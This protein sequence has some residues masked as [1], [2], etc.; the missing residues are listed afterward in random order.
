MKTNSQNKGFTLIE[1]VIVMV[2]GGLLLVVGAQA[3]TTY[4]SN[5]NRKVTKDRIGVIVEQIELFLEENERLPCVARHN[6]AINSATFGRALDD[7]GVAGG[8]VGCTLAAPAPPPLPAVATAAGGSVFIGSVPTRTLNLPDNFMVDGWGNRILYAVTRTQTNN[9]VAGDG[10]IDIRDTNNNAVVLPAG[11]ADFIVFSTGANK[12]GGWTLQG[13]QTGGCAAVAAA[14]NDQENCDSDGVF[15]TTMM[16]AEG[17]VNQYDDIV[18]YRRIASKNI[19]V[20]ADVVLPIER[21]GPL[22]DTCPAGW[23][24]PVP[25]LPNNGNLVYCKKL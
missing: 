3:F 22:A 25:A 5:I 1:L 20:P 15:A 19:V 24:K 12:V 4:M 21:L 9:F 11:E 8:A 17:A 2:I 13:V 10:G 16:T 18:S 23:A 14:Q 7:D 6:D